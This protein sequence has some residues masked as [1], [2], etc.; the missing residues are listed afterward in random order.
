MHPPFSR[1][2]SLAETVA[3]TLN[4]FNSLSLKE[5]LEE[6]DATHDS[7][8]VQQGGLFYLEQPQNLERANAFIKRFLEGKHIDPEQKI[9]HLF[10]HLHQIGLVVDGY[11]GEKSGTYDVYQ[12]GKEIRNPEEDDDTTNSLMFPRRRMKGNLMI[13]KT[14]VPGGQYMIDAE[15][16]MSKA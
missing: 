5:Y 12:Y 1:K 7:P 4:R 11:R 14:M 10:G 2:N 16:Y 13:K 6:G 15:L 3:S 8:Q 9:N